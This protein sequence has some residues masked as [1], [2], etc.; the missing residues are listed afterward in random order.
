[1]LLHLHL[2]H[3]LLWLQLEFG[4]LFLLLLLLLRLAVWYAIADEIGLITLVLADFEVVLS[5]RLFGVWLS[6]LEI[7]EGFF[8]V[9]LSIRLTLVELFGYFSFR[10]ESRFTWDLWWLGFRFWDPWRIFEGFFEVLVIF[11]RTCCPT[12]WFLSICFVIFGWFKDALRDPWGF[13]DGCQQNE[14][15]FQGFFRIIWGVIVYWLI[16]EG[17]FGFRPFLMIWSGFGDC[18][19][20]LRRVFEVSFGNLQDSWRFSR[21]VWDS[22]KIPQLDFTTLA[23]SDPIWRSWTIQLITCQIKTRSNQL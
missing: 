12:A 11:F 7:L 17:F 2:F 6:R 4:L 23:L 5:I 3:L 22:L 8:E 10:L 1:M 16:L 18:W 19:M 20:T 21:A 9:A 15:I 14:G 13:F